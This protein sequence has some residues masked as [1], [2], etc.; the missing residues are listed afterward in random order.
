M[1]VIL[2]GASC[3]KWLASLLSIPSEQALLALIEKVAPSDQPVTSNAP[4]FL[5]WLSGERTPHNDPLARGSFVNLTHDTSAAMLGY[6]V[7]EGVGFALRDALHSVESAGA[8]VSTCSLVG[9]GARSA[10]WTQLLANILGIELQTLSG[11]E[12]SGCIGGAKL[13][14]LASG[15][16]P[17]LLAMG[18]SPKSVFRP[19]P[20]QKT[21]LQ[22]R[23]E[24]F[25]G[26]YPALRLWNLQTSKTPVARDDAD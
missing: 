8:L 26:L 7:L 1:G 10:Y 17:E 25:R 21:A 4:M 18:V 23:Y 19:Q 14:Y 6:A 2:S 16:G 20:S 11:S 15:H 9:G 3:L 12:F 13:G 24:K 5:P 22:D